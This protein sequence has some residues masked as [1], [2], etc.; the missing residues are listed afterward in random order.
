MLVGKTNVFLVETAR[1]Q[2]FVGH[3]REC[4]CRV[5]SV[6]RLQKMLVSEPILVEK[7]IISAAISWAAAMKCG[8]LA[9]SLGNV[10]GFVAMSLAHDRSICM[11]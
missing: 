7:F 5:R 1:F 11:F 4:Q 6:A 10:M 8:S 3:T 2:M 9:R